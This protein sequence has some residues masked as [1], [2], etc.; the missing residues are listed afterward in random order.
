[1]GRSASPIA[2]STSRLGR[3]VGERLG[4]HIWV[5]GWGTCAII[6][7]VQIKETSR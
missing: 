2:M 1:M 5:N 6:C 7:G 4:F 3:I